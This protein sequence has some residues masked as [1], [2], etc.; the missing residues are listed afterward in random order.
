MCSFLASCAP[1]SLE[2]LRA[3]GRAQTRLLAADLRKIET[4]EDLQKAAPCLRERFNQIASLLI[5]A[6]KYTCS[7]SEPSPES[8]ALFAELARIY[9]MPGGREEIERSQMQAVQKIQKRF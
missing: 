8:D 1:S 9:E 3:E 6:K 7:E 2:D 4:K 5:E